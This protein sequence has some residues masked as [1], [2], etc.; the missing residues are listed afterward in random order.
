MILAFN[1]ITNKRKWEDDTTI[2]EVKRTEE[3]LCCIL[4][5]SRLSIKGIN[6]FSIR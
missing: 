5:N 3:L 1:N 2:E 6:P 4:L